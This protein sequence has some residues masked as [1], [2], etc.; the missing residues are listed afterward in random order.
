MGSLSNPLNFSRSIRLERT[1]EEEK[2]RGCT[3]RDYNGH[4]L[5]SGGR[6]G[7]K[8]SRRKRGKPKNDLFPGGGS[9]G[10]HWSAPEARRTL[11][12]GYKLL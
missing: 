8:G 6:G 9:R 11:E 4:F 3:E 2:K 1:N 7:G 10:N 12:G 5:V